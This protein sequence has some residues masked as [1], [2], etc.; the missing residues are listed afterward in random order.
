MLVNDVA[1][2]VA[3]LG[4]LTLAS[5]YCVF[6]PLDVKGIVTVPSALAQVRVCLL[7]NEQIGT[8]NIWMRFRAI[9][10]VSSA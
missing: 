1:F 8:E 5:R 6:G 9:P 2:T 10:I 3:E 4:V 7:V